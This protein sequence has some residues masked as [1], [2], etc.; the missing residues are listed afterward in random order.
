MSFAAVVSLPPRA[1]LPPCQHMPSLAPPLA[2]KDPAALCCEGVRADHP[3]RG[4]WRA[5]RRRSPAQ[6]NAPGAAGGW[7]STALRFREHPSQTSLCFLHSH[8][9]NILSLTEPERQ[10]GCGGMTHSLCVDCKLFSPLDH[11]WLV[12]RGPPHAATAS[13]VRGEERYC[14]GKGGGGAQ[15]FTAV[16]RTR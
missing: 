4:R 11:P 5:R 9:I 2:P 14:R 10:R 3:Y 8:G 6:P 13:G 7:G 16:A 1:A 15:L 12:G